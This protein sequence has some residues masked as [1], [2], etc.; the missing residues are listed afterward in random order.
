R[1]AVDDVHLDEF[2]C[3]FMAHGRMR[4]PVA[5]QHAL[6]IELHLFPQRT[7]QAVQHA[8]LHRVF[9]TPGVDNET[10]VVGADQ[11]FGEDAAGL[12]VH[13]HFGDDRHYRAVAVREGHTAADGDRTTIA[14]WCGTG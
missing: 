6:F 4:H 14:G 11:A 5:A 2:R 1:I 9:E 7:A 13:F 12:P 8:A 3:V 10:T